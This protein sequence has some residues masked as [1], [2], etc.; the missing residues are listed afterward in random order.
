MPPLRHITFINGNTEI[1]FG[2]YC[3]S[4]DLEHYGIKRL[5]QTVKNPLDFKIKK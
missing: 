1:T 4:K 5:E 2:V 3:S